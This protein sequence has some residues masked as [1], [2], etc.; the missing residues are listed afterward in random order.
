MRGKLSAFWGYDFVGVDLAREALD[1]LKSQ[2]SPV[3]IATAERVSL[4]EIPDESLS[5]QLKELKSKPD[6]VQIN[7]IDPHGTEVASILAGKKPFG[8]A[9]KAQY[10]A[11]GQGMLEEK[12][13]ALSFVDRALDRKIQMFTA[14]HCMSG[15]NSDPDTQS[16][17]SCA[18]Q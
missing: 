11:V 18:A 6:S 15:S 1:S 17:I 12:T 7:S 14:S 2:M 5:N 16:W 9:M 8:V 13:T 3:R 4:E 10:V